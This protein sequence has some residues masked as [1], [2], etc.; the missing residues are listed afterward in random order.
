MINAVYK[1][2]EP[3]LIDVAYED[4]SIDSDKVIIHPLKLSICKADQRY[5][6]GIRSREILKK[7]L[8]MALIHECCAEVVFDPTGTFKPGQKVIPIP[9]IPTQD[10][11]II[12]ENYRYSSFFRGSGYDRFMQ[13]YITSVPERLVAIPDSMNLTVAAFTELISVCTHTITRFGKISHARKN[14]IGIWGDGNVGFITSLLLHYIYPDAELYV[15]GTVY[16][17]LSY[18]TFANAAYHVDALPE[19]FGVDHA[20]ECVG[21]A[22]SRSAINQIIDHINPEGTVALMGVSENNID[23]NT[24][25]ILEKGL[26]FFGS[27]RSGKADFIKTVELIHS[28]PEI[29]RYLENIVGEEI[30]VSSI[31]DIH[32][33]FE[34]DFSRNFGKTVMNWNK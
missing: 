34:H 6:Q 3:R 5:Y 17:K 26:F 16:E 7:K 8:P 18:F 24:R 27:S 30:T 1:L 12:A 15:M 20:F 25:M 22:G 11:D 10:D 9:N 29:S 2:I 23:I 28:H 13:D 33:A 14:K 32:K 31:T 19:D 21:G 4:L